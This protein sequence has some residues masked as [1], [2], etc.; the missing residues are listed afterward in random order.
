MHRRTLL[1]ALAIAGSGADRA[2]ASGPIQVVATF[3]ILADMAAVVGGEDVSVRSLVPADADAHVWEPK[4]ADLR[5][6][7][8]AQVLIENGL[9]LEEW[10]TRMPRAAGFKGQLITASQNV[11]PSTIL[12]DGRRVVDPHAWQDPRN[13]VLYVR[14]ITDALAAAAPDREAV[15][16]ARSAA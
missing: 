2:F 16:H 8:G 15:I 10:M 11:A 13:G 4:Q 7:Q 14:V 5:A 12:E 1:A 9:G 3:S 6:L